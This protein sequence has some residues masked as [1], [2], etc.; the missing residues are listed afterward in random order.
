MSQSAHTLSAPMTGDFRSDTVTL[1]TP[2]M[3]AAMS[4]AALGD[5]VYGEDSTVNLLEAKVA[6]LCGK[7]AAVFCPTGTM[8]NQIGMRI[9]LQPLQ[10][11]LCDARCHIFNYES[12]GVAYHSQAQLYPIKPK[13]GHHLTLEDIADT[14]EDTDGLHKPYMTVIALENT[15]GGL[16]M[17]I[18]EI[19]CISEYAKSKNMKMHLD[20]ARL[21]NANVKTGISIKEYCQYFDTVSLCFSKGLGAP[22][23]SC[24]VGTAADMKKAKHYRKLL[25]GGW[26]QAGGLAAAAMYALDKHWERMSQDHANAFRLFSGLQAAGFLCNTPETNMVWVNVLDKERAWD[27]IVKDL[28]QQGIVI[29]KPGHGLLRLV[30]H[31]QIETAHVDK[32]VDLLSKYA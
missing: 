28:K 24:I 6:E 3:I 19:Q 32:L 23:G 30:C 10:A 11:A 18:E 29:G 22:I 26:R 7:E 13:N 17:P 14:Y 20:G 12:G 1:P 4:A 5:D 8:T 25:G 9:N 21:W 31:L 2:E 27:I 16:V 15:I